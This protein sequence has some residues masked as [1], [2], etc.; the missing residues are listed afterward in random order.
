[1]KMLQSKNEMVKFWLYM[2]FTCSSLLCFCFSLAFF[3]WSLYEKTITNCLVHWQY[4]WLNEAIWPIL[5][6]GIV[7]VVMILFRPSGDK[8]RFVYVPLEQED[9]ENDEEEEFMMSDSFDAFTKYNHILKEITSLPDKFA[10][11]IWI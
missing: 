8:Q 9:D 5:F 11:T 7:V 1:M 6:S 2:Y 10:M 4:L 3:V